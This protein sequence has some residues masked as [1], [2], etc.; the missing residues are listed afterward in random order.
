MFFMRYSLLLSCLVVTGLSACA[1]GN[2][3]V[4]RYS[5]TTQ[6]TTR[7]N[8]AS[9]LTPEQSSGLIVL[10]GDTTTPVQLRFLA[11]ERSTTPSDWRTAASGDPARQ[12]ISAL[13]AANLSP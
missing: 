7:V 3:P 5:A 9:Y 13:A 11:A 12:E 4:S 10:P 6:T 2:A 8:T 1:P